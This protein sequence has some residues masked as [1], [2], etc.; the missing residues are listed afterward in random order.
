MV[1]MLRG[2]SAIATALALGLGVTVAAA[3]DTDVPFPVQQFGEVRIYR[4]PYFV[5]VQTDT[6]PLFEHPVPTKKRG[7]WKMA[8]LDN[9]YKLSNP[10]FLDLLRPVRSQDRIRQSVEGASAHPRIG[11]R[12][13]ARAPR[14][15]HRDGRRR[16][17][18]NRQ[19]VR[20]RVPE[21]AA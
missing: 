9:G 14:S 6:L 3:E 17:P 16:R 11:N 1:V 7:G 13:C 8:Y 19:A 10:L 12:V 2:F 4:V 18:E 5:G 15:G 21:A 20:A